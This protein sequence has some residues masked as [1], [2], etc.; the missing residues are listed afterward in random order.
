M[1]LDDLNELVGTL[2]ERIEQHKDVLSK[3]ETATRYALIDPL[4]T[5]L[6]W[7]LQDPGQVRTEYRSDD[8]SDRRRRDYTMFTGEDNAGGDKKKPQLVI[9]AKH[10]DT[11]IGDKIIDQTI[12]YCVR[13]G[14]PYFAV[15]NGSD[16]EIYK[17]FGE[18]HIRIEDRRIV[19][20]K[21]TAP[22]QT[23]VMKMLWLWRG[24][25][26]SESPIVPVAPDRPVS[27]QAATSAPQPA[28]A[29][30][31]P[32][33]QQPDRGIPLDK[34]SPGKGD[35]PP[36]TLLFPNGTEKNIAKWYE[37][38]TSVVGW[39][40]DTGRLAEADCPVK[41]PGGRHLVATSPFKRN[42]NPFQRP[43][44]I[45]SVWVDID[46]VASNHIKAAKEILIARNVDLSDVRVVERT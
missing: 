9:E 28:A 41:G 29:A 5:A 20:F 36:A 40:I 32:S 7:D 18:P 21:L 35:R 37:I 1:W 23:T 24:N 31:T 46:K 26:E 4:L 12:G 13:E 42:D 10:L 11:P 43:K 2:K 44:Q 19:D 30:P 14:I 33:V 6:G 16:W 38:Q 34:F 3:N 17:T 15:T 45:G 25:F 27:Q 8:N 39:L 22:T